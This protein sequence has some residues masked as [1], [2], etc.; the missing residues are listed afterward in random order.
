MTEK[1]FIS[2]SFKTQYNSTGRVFKLELPSKC[3]HCGRIM[4]PDVEA[5]TDDKNL[6][7]ALLLKCTYCGKYFV[8]AYELISPE[9]FHLIEYSYSAIIDYDLP[10]ELEEF[11][12]TGVEIYK[13]ALKA[14]YYN[15]DQI[16]GIG[17]R[18]AL[19]YF[20]KDFLVNERNKTEYTERAIPLMQ[21]IKELNFDKMINLATAATWIGNDETHYLKKYSKS[22]VDNMKKFI[23]ALAFYLSAERSAGKAASFISEK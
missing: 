10:I 19:E 2:E 4:T 5:S 6:K 15:L 12:P 21:A 7:A 14:E 13:Q 3:I 11:S 8:A 1:T 17:F 20:I 18:K 16:S 23:K 9:H 22:E